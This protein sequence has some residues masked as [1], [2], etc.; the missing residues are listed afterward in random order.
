MPE[1]EHVT[2]AKR[3][4]QLLDKL[5]ELTDDVLDLVLDELWQVHHPGED[6]KR[7]PRL[8]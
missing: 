8:P 3:L 5:I 2:R 4:Q 6:R 1:N 7:P